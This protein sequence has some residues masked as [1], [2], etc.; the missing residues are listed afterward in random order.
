V[1]RHLLIWVALGLALSG[2]GACGPTCG[3]ERNCGNTNS[4]SAGRSGTP[5]CDQL[6][7]L[8]TCMD[9]FCATN[10]NP[11]CTC[12]KRGY[13][14]SSVSCSCVDFDAEKFCDDQAASGVTYDCSAAIGAVGTTCVGVQ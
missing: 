5:T 11:F 7:A 10:T 3:T 12:Y 6:T 2:A 4:S 1:S 14:L 9:S 13:D 8:R